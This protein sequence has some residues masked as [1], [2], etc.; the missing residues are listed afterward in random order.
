VDVQD[1]TWRGTIRPSDTT[2]WFASYDAFLT[3]YAAL[4][5]Q[6]GVELLDVGTELAT[7]SDW[8]NA[9]SWTTIISHVRSAYS[10]PLT[11]SANANA[12]G[13]E[14]TSVSFW[15]LLDVAGL[16]V[17]VP[18]TNRIGPSKDELIQAW[19]RNVNGHDMVAAYRNWQAGHGK[20]VIF[21]EI[22]YRSV[23]GANRAPWD[24]TFQGTPDPVEQANCYDAAFTVW[25]QESSWMKGT[26]W[27]A[28]PTTPPGPADTDYTPRGKAAEGVLQSWY[29]G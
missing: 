1:G 13:D 24:F 28:W 2:A 22:G 4:A 14:F 16:D 29:G 11:Y 3:H 21:T 8:R 19:R 25:S 7:M 23:A 18:L 12:T 15:N 26:F 10:G 6:N 20:P 17:Y 9:S 5:Q 27:W